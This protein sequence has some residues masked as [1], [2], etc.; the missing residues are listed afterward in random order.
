[1]GMPRPEHPRP[2]FQ[3]S[4]WMNLNGK[5]QFE[6]DPKKIGFEDGWHSQKDYS[7]RI[8]VPFPPESVLSGI[9]ITGFMESVWYRRFFDIPDSWMDGR[10]LLHFGAVDY[11]ARIYVNGCEAGGHR[12][13]YTPFTCDISDVARGRNNELVVWAGDDCRSGLQPTGKQSH[14]L[15]S[16]RCLYSRVTGIWQTVWA[17]SVTNCGVTSAIWTLVSAALSGERNVGHSAGLRNSFPHSSI[18]WLISRK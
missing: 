3:R 1:M 12:G 9:G 6:I 8:I 11:E 2:D 16:Y 15:E 14:R 5:W 4:D 18:T 10:I 17:E 7:Q 13:G